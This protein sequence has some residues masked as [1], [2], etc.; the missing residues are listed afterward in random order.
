M[1]PLLLDPYRPRRG[2]GTGL[3][4]RALTLRPEVPEGTSQPQGGFKLAAGLEPPVAVVGGAGGAG[5]VD[6]HGHG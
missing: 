3:H 1:D 4:H 6:G 2:G 5:A